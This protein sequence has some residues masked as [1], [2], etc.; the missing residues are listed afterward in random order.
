MPR[1]RPRDGPAVNNLVYFAAV[2]LFLPWLINAQQQQRQPVRQRQESPHEGHDREVS[3]TI[4]VTK[5]PPTLETPFSNE[6]RKKTLVNNLNKIDK[7]ASALETLAPVNPL[8]SAVA[9]PPA[10]PSSIIN[11]GLTTPQIARDIAD[12]EVEDFVLMATID[13]KL[14]AR[15]RK[16]GQEKWAIEATPMVKTEYH[17]PYRDRNDSSFDD[18]DLNTIDNYLWVVEP[19]KDGN[20]YIF[21]PG[22]PNYGLFPTGLTMKQ[23]VEESPRAEQDPP[24]LYTGSKN[25]TML[26]IDAHTGEVTSWFGTENSLKYQDAKC[27]PSSINSDSCRFKTLTFGQTTYTVA[28]HNQRDKRHIATLTFSEWTP[29]NYDKD[30]LHQY[31]T[32]FDKKYIY[33]SQD[34]KMFGVDYKTYDKKNS[35]RPHMLFQHTLSSPVARVFDVARP[36]GPEQETEDLIVL[37]QPSAPNKGFF[38]TPN[39]VFMNHTEDGSFYGM[40]GQFYALADNIPSAGCYLPGWLQHRPQWDVTNT[41]QL[42]KALVGLHSIERGVVR[43]P[44]KPFM[45]IEAPPT[46]EDNATEDVGLDTEVAFLRPPTLMQPLIEQILSLVQVFRNPLF[47]VLVVVGVFY[48]RDSILGWL[49]GQRGGKFAVARPS[50]QEAA[51]EASLAPEKLLAEAPEETEKLP[52]IPENDVVLVAATDA[53]AETA[54]LAS[55]DA[56]KAKVPDLKA[57]LKDADP[58]SLEASVDEKPSPTADKDKEREKKK[59]RGR[60]GGVKHRKGPRP[61][62]QGHSEDGSPPHGPPTI[63]DAVRD[64]Q[65][66]GPQKTEIEPDIR[67]MPSDPQDVEGPIIRIGALEVNTEK[68]IGTGSNGTLVFEGNFDGRAVAVKRM[69]MQFFDIASQETK[70]LRE[71]DD[72]PN[73]IRYFAQQQAGGFLYIALEL[74]PASLADVISKPQLHRALAQAGERD[75][76]D[77]LYQITMGL[78]HLHKLRI[79]HRDLKPQ[80]ILVSLDK[81]G[82]PRLLVSDF[83]LCKKLEGEQ[84]SFRAT[85]AHAAGTSGWR[86]PELLLD[87]DA[88]DGHIHL[89]NAD[90]STEGNSGAILKDADPLPSRRATRAID[91]FSLGLVFFYV[92]TKGCHPFD[93]GDRYMREINIR[94]GI[95][96]LDRLEILGDYA[97]EAKDLIKSMLSAEPRRRPAAKDVM[98]HPFFWPAKRRLE[99]LCNVSDYFEKEKRDPPTGPLL[100]LEDHA[101]AICGSDF[102]KPLGKEFVDSLGK[103]RKYTGTRLLDLL[104]ALRNKKNHYEDMTESLKRHV[105]PLP[106]GYLNF[107]TRRFP[108][109]LITCWNIVYEIGW[110]NTDRFREYYEP[111]GSS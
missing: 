50:I 74:C 101:T 87:D 2:V 66:M 31:R 64:A 41:A 96:N 67:T 48:Q 22:G 84:S 76:P 62:S 40:S 60:R 6:R 28:I 10:R 63:E 33:T 21:R 80:N 56:A 85:T 75:L 57:R 71:S 95:M 26:T 69:L 70:L 49:T 72:H 44:R 34:G 61:Q 47:W 15:D 55:D 20:L 17:D 37:S 4:E 7:D 25:T 27:F 65:K 83:G 5:I 9:A 38:Q 29:N 59:P 82:K 73:V 105:G 79:V 36:G 11:A 106:D 12:W 13:G 24:V 93:S 104:R 3:S 52:D 102:L 78:S 92:L 109:L 42:S 77:V 88:K 58:P 23:L 86:A 54:S 94:K 68:L 107:W 97:F 46:I 51:V 108:S 99:F 91:I 98:A 14:H 16:T 103:Q 110:E 1:R 35:R 81:D 18:Y 19:S 111:I 100:Q 89:T 45:S 43:E 39:D 8:G 53:P 90:A 32:T 30:L